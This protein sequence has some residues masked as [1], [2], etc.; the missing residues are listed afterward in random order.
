MNS[1]E[2]QYIVLPKNALTEGSGSRNGVLGL[3]I[4]AGYDKVANGF[5]RRDQIEQ[6]DFIFRGIKGSGALATQ[7][8]LFRQQPL[9]MLMGSDVLA[10]AD[11]NALSLGVRSEIQKLVPLDIGE[12]RMRFLVPNESRSQT[13]AD[14]ESR[15]IFSKYAGLAERTL[16]AM[17]VRTLVRQTEGADTRVNEYRT[18]QPRVGAF[19][20][21][22]SGDTA[23]QNNLQIVEGFSYPSG[24]S[25]GL[26]YLDLN[27]IT[28]DFSMS[29][30]ASASN[31]S[32]DMLREMGL[33]LESAR[34]V[35]R[36]VT[37]QFN[38][39]ASEA[40]AFSDLGMKGPTISP[41]LT[42]DGEKWVS[43]TIS[44]PEGNQNAMRAKLMS[45]G[46]KD[47]LTSS[48]L[49]A[50]PDPDT[51]SVIR[52]LPFDDMRAGR[53]DA[54]DDREESRQK[55]ADWLLGLAETVRKRAESGDEQSS[56]VR[57]LR[58]GPE[59]CAARYV[60]E[61]GELSK[62]IRTETTK[63]AIAEAGQCFYWF[64]VSLQSK[65]YSFDEVLASLLSDQDQ[66]SKD[67]L[68]AVLSSVERTTTFVGSGGI[69][70]E[71]VDFSDDTMT[72]STA[73]RKKSKDEALSAAA[74]S[75]QKLLSLLKIA[76]IDLIA[77]MEAERG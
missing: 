12:C 75:L 48:P 66:A 53:S 76:D 1:A 37:F 65:G 25:L 69:N 10:E 77:V 73:L 2:K 63:A 8:E 68:C 51:S 52:I 19:E 74:R 13:E 6:G 3:L 56:T 60:G 7:L 67:T 35:N 28:T 72:F 17:N 34:T 55:T 31:R 23:R 26:P 18:L 33:A 27:R 43:V 9:G 54:L 46:A 61:A 38:A 30:I 32:R 62:A 11:I 44:V 45:R 70:A 16:G 15:L 4:A 36:F 59:L 5:D 42:R 21:V 58:Q 50:E 49:S 29:N 39:R 20:I 22:G 40:N 14:L 64:L 41:L 47:L 24:E 57:A 71:A